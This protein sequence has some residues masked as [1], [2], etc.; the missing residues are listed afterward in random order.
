MKVEGIPEHVDPMVVLCNDN[1]YLVVYTHL[2]NE[3]ALEL[4]KRAVEV[5]KYEQQLDNESSGQL[6]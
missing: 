4:L 3:A 1:E 2:T 5:L 6:H